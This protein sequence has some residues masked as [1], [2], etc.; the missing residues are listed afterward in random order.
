MDVVQSQRWSSGDWQGKQSIR[1][2]GVA[3][4]ELWVGASKARR[5]FECADLVNI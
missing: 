2:M 4:K 3:V 1:D 5:T